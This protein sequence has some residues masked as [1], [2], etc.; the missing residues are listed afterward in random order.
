MRILGNPNGFSLVEI[1]VGVGLIGGLAYWSMQTLSVQEKL[2]K[3][4]EVKN[5]QQAVF[6]DIGQILSSS[7]ACT[8][9]FQGWVADPVTS[10]PQSGSI[11]YQDKSG[12]AAQL[13]Y[14]INTNQALATK[15]GNGTLQLTGIRLARDAVNNIPVGQ[16]KGSTNLYIRFYFGQNK[17]KGA[18]VIERKIPLRVEIDTLASRRVVSCSAA[19]STSVLDNIYL[20]LTGGTMRGDIIMSDGTSINFLSDRRLKEEVRMLEPVLPKIHQLQPVNYS[21]KDN[22]RNDHGFIAQNVEAVFPQVVDVGSS[23][24]LQVDYVQLTPIMLKGLQEVDS[25]SISL[26]KKINRMKSE[27]SEMARLVEG[28]K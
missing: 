1:L 20:L 9:T 28:L 26:G 6:E 27:Q 23:G 22:G 15:Y 7:D 8:R 2:T 13:R 4:V 17:I 16:L 14:S 24:F 19:G 11:Y 5:E 10:T 21:W 12:A 3:T 25:E 18:S